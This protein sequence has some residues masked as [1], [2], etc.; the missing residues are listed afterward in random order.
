MHDGQPAS[1]DD[2]LRGLQTSGLAW[3]GR[4]LWSVGDQRS[5]FAGCLLPIDPQTGRLVRPPVPLVAERPEI[6]KQLDTWGR[7][8]A[9]GIDVLSR[10]ERRFV[11]LLESNAMAALVVRV[12][13]SGDRAVVE[14][15]WE[16]DFPAGTAPEPYRGDPN[17]R[18]EGI[19]IDVYG[20][21]GYAAYERDKSGRPRLFQFDL[22]RTTHS[23]IGQVLL[24]PLAFDGW[25]ELAGKP[26]TLLNFNGLELIHTTAGEPRLLVLCR[27]RELLVVLHPRTGKLLGQ[28]A[29]DLRSPNGE[30][31][32]WPS[33]EGVAFDDRR[34]VVY[35][36]SDPDSTNG[37]W[38]LRSTPTATGFFKL[39]VP[40]LFE[41]RLP[42]GILGPE[43]RVRCTLPT[44][45]RSRT[46]NLARTRAIAELV[47]EE[48]EH[49]GGRRITGGASVG[50]A[51]QLFALSP[52]T[53]ST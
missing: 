12:T 3:D 18:F 53:K 19:A 34:G 7:L 25:E 46:T 52:E 11:V 8:D 41:F 1:S 24:E 49:L 47:A 30:P 21:R 37:N 14:A 48:D 6:R 42:P 31:I 32:E 16:F 51:N 15:V 29:L 33:P 4:L 22:R 28:A 39:Y 43:N 17:F 5:T 35:L 2:A 44:A 50:V 20:S 38:R 26:G 45:S 13:E 23:G 27:D 9:E 10:A 36:I 40:L